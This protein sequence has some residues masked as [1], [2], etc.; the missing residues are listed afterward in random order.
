MNESYNLAVINVHF[1][2]KRGVLTKIVSTLISPDPWLF[3]VCRYRGVV[4]ISYNLI[5]ENASTSYAS[6][7][8]F[9]GIVFEKLAT[10]VQDIDSYIVTECKLKGAKCLIAGEIDCKDDDQYV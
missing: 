3:K 8:C 1:V 9:S 6:Q 4:Y 10:A 5:R 7:S 2:C